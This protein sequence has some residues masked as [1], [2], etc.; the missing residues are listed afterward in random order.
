MGTTGSTLRRPLRCPKTPVTSNS[1][2]SA[3]KSP[4]LN[5]VNYFH[6]IIIRISFF[7]FFFFFCFEKSTSNSLLGYFSMNF[8]VGCQVSRKK[9]FFFIVF[10]FRDDLTLMKE[11]MIKNYNLFVRVLD[12]WKR[13]MM[14]R[15]Y[16]EWSQYSLVPFHLVLIPCNSIAIKFIKLMGSR[17]TIGLG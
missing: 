13:N 4:P 15:E 11:L 17:H 9:T 1:S 3:T 10:F 8:N 2:P 16:T 14:G 12:S 5:Y 6:L 7:F